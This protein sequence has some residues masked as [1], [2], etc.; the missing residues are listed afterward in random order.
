MQRLPHADGWPHSLTTFSPDYARRTL[1][2]SLISVGMGFTVL[3]PVLAPLGREIGLTEVQ[4]TFIIGASALMVFLAS[5]IWGRASDRF[6]RKRVLLFG[7][8]GFAAGTVLFNSVLYAGMTGVLTGT[9][10]FAALVIARMLHA[11]VMAA[12]MPA[13]NAYMADITTPENRTKGMGA[14]GAANNLGAI[15]GPAIAG[16]AVISLL[17]PLWVMAVVALLNGLF[18]WRFLPEPPK[19]H[20]A[21]PHPAGPHP[22]EH[23]APRKPPRL[24]Y[25]D[26][27]ILP[28]V[29]V[30]VVMFSGMA[31]VQQT[32]GFRFQ[33]VLELSA[34]DTAKAVGL[35]MMGSAVFSLLAQGF[36]VQRLT[37]P[38]FTLLK[39]AMPLLILA[40]TLMALVE[41]QLWLTVAMMIQGFGMGL[42]GPG[43]MAGASLAV[44]PQEQGSVAGVAGS[45]GPLGFAIGPLLGGALYQFGP[46]LP[47]VVAAGVYVLLFASMFWIGRRV[48]VHR[49]PAA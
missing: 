34:A 29:V 18:V 1:L 44:S 16:L 10:L 15:L 25:T 4:I 39:L 22:P 37:L 48:T 46:A 27:R 9:V 21:G 26:R 43:F 2:I 33:D 7:L 17:A 5:P 47:Y 38:P 31:L 19:P 42:A 40:F 32:M 14:A 49:E 45:C 20:P 28:F 13:A 30:G 3:F 11:A 24:R 23:S 8:F 41:S 35:A 36:V 6:G 12:S